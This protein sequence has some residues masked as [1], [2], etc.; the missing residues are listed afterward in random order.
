MYLVLSLKLGATPTQTSSAL[1]TNT[2]V[3]R[4]FSATFS[5]HTGQ[6]TP[7]VFR[8]TVPTIAAPI[9]RT[10]E[11]ILSSVASSEPPQTVTP[12]LEASA[13][14]IAVDVAPLPMLTPPESQAVPV[15]EQTQTA[16]PS[17]LV[18]EGQTAQ[19]SGSEDAAA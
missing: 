1:V 4:S 8:V 10:T 11:M 5:E 3:S 15:T 7:L 12:T 17:L 13:T 19:S 2:P 18:I 6:P 16:S 14:A 9:T